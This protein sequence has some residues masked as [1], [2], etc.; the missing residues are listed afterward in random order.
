MSTGPYEALRRRAAERIGEL[1]LDPLEDGETIRA[2]VDQLVSAYQ[3]SAFG[4]GGVRPFRDPVEIGARLVDS[5]VG[6]GPLTAG[7]RP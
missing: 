5:L 7:D 4:G 1:E 6:Y 2:E 3:R